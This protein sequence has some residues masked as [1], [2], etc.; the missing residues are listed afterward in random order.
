MATQGIEQHFENYRQWRTDLFDGIGGL[1]DWLK[2]QNLS[3]AQLE[4]R[5]DAVQAT[6]RDDKLYIAFVAEFSRGKSELINALFF[7][8]MGKRILPSSAGRTT[9]CPTELMYDSGF[10]PFLKLLP[11]ET[12]NSGTSIAEYKGFDDEWTVVKLPVNSPEKMIEVLKHLAQVK[13]VT[14]K[15]ATALGFKIAEDGGSDGIEVSEDGTVEIPKWR[16]ALIN[17][18]HPLLE[19]GLVILDTPGLNALGAEP[20]LT[21]SMLPGAHGVLFILAADAGVTKSDI[22]VWHDHI[23]SKKGGSSRGRMV[24]LNKIDGLWDELRDDAEVNKEIARQVTDTARHL[25]IPENN[26]FPVSAQKGLAAKIKKDKKLLARSRITELEDAL[27][28]QIVPAKREIV[29]DNINDDMSEFITSIR[30]VINQRVKGAQEHIDELSSL[31]GKN[32]DVVEHMMEKV[33]KD[34]EVFEKSL[35]RFQATRSIFSQQTN[36]LYS[37][38]NLKKLDSVIAETKRNMEISMTTA[39]LRSQMQEFFASSLKTMEE[40]AKQAQEIKALMEGVYQKFQQEHGLSNIKPSGF[41]VMRYMRELK[42][43]QTKHDQFVNSMSMMMMEQK[44]VSRSFYD[45]VVSKIR[46]IFKMANRD[47][48][49]WLKNIM[50]P[51]ESQVRE[52][53]VQL[54]RRLESIKRIHQ[55][56]DT[57]EDRLD[58]L[59]TARDGVRK[60][61]QDLEARLGKVLDLLHYETAEARRQRKRS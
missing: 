7:G 19:Q 20:E 50:S 23:G 31:S 41:S 60:Q 32:Q 40:V 6:L 51:M 49:N 5:L 9:M 4:Q 45:T 44:A 17:F 37:H 15:Q 2:E 26:I 21:I 8:G 34:K 56:S 27:G 61:E 22:E 57:L 12:R 36:V 43:L 14:V 29:R 58:E 10:K 42:R 30:A 38:L 46:A 13:T 33:R 47:A 18:P 39:G 35:Q 52:H 55:A 48:D 54:R 1:R 28:N 11:I 16:H 59:N 24:V 3:D 53:Q 25:D